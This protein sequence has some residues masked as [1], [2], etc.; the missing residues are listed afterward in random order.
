MCGKIC[1]E[2]YIVVAIGSHLTFMNAFRGDI[3]RS[4]F[5]PI[6]PPRSLPRKVAGF[7][8]LGVLRQNIDYALLVMR[9]WTLEPLKC[10]S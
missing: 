8:V 1:K 6:F 5:F 3:L 4:F 9:E 7:P 2:Y 10:L